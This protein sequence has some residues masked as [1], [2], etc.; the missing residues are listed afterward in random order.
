MAGDVG[1]GWM[2]EGSLVLVGR[3]SGMVAHLLAQQLPRH[4]ARIVQEGSREVPHGRCA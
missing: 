1:G 3:I 4:H 2:D